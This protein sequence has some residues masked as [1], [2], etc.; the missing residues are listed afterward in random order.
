[1]HVEKAKGDNTHEE[2][3]LSSDDLDGATPARRRNGTQADEE[4]LQERDRHIAK[5]S[6]AIVATGVSAATRSSREPLPT[7]ERRRQTQGAR[8]RCLSQKYNLRICT[9]SYYHMIL[10]YYDYY[11]Y[12]LIDL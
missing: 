7:T 3:E 9:G 6:S 11:L 1:M 10:I 4:D 8:G 12:K 5:L 2:E